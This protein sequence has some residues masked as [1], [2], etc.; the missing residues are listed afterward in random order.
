MQLHDDDKEGWK[1][2]DILEI[3][4]H[5]LIGCSGKP[6]SL[7]NQIK[8][9]DIVLI[10]HGGDVLALTQAL[11]N[12][13][14]I[15]SDEKNEYIWF[16]V[17]L[18]VRV[19]EYYVKKSVWGKGWFIPKTLMSIDNDIAYNFVANLYEE[20]KNKMMVKD[21]IS[22]LKYKHQVIL[23]GAPGTGK[24]YTA[25]NIAY[26][27]IFGNHLS[28]EKEARKQQTKELEVTEQYKLIQFHPAYSYEDF[29]RG[30]VVESKGSQVE[31]RTKDKVLAEFAKTALKNY[32]DHLKTPEIISKEQG[33]QILFEDFKDAI[34]NEI[35]SSQGK[36]NIN[37]TV[38]ISEITENAFRYGG[39]N[40]GNTQRMKFEAIQKLY[41]ANITERKQIKNLPNI[42]RLAV[43]HAT[44]YFLLFKKFQEFIKDRRVESIPQR[45]ELK[46]YVLII[47]E[48]NRAN[49]PSVLG[50]LIYALEY[51]GESVES[52]YDIDGD[53]SLILP[54]NLYIIGTMNTADRSVGHI[55]YAI[56]RRFA[57]VD[58]PAD[59]SVISLD[60]AKKLFSDVKAI[61]KEHLTSDFELNDIELGHSY[62]LAQDDAELALKLKYEIKPILREYVKD[63]ILLNGAKKEIENLNV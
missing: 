7:F 19:L 35:D 41:L 50:E 37:D 21:F 54:P 57:F 36:F 58:I 63:G 24:T 51:R 3:L 32:E 14:N 26:R 20:F 59:E 39:D 62:Y 10:R 28:T 23:Q 60:K 2:D 9:G 12:P 38:H 40:W 45:V 8:S 44:Y 1:R 56:R 30:I 31:Y 5:S 18:K 53:R 46:N 16:D 43:Q 11:E 13:R 27:L 4:K 49:L 42:N 22:L 17:G 25:K 55:D 15:T 48:I 34:Q 6:V 33:F 47:D 29:V 61:F 52:M